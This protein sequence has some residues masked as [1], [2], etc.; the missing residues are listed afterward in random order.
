MRRRWF[1]HVQ[2]RINSRLARSSGRMHG[3]GPLLVAIGDSHTDPT[4]AFTRPGQV[5]LRIVARA[6]YR[7]L[8]LGVSGDTT[9]QMRQRIGQ[10]LSDGRPDIVVLFGGGN[11]ALRDV[12]PVET[13]RNVAFMIEWLR[14]H[15]VGQIVLIGAVQLNWR[16]TAWWQPRVEEV[17]RILRTLAARYS[18]GFVD[19]AGFLGE[20]IAQGR[21]PDFSAVPY[22]QSRSWHVYGGDPHFNAYGQRLIAEAFLG[23]R[24][25]WPAA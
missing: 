12:D 5:W 19:L 18:V 16:E 7:T 4:A 6:G 23:S 11:D 8:N 15:S 3:S 20:R 2:R 25:D 10:A 21:D 1:W 9:A 24:A 13:E 14:D 22:R 17:N